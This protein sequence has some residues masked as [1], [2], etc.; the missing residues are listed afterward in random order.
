MSPI[1]SNNRS[2]E[3]VCL[4][5]TGLILVP[6]AAGWCLRQY[7][8]RKHTVVKE[9]QRSGKARPDDKR[10]KGTAV[11]CG[12]SI[13]GLWTAR[14]CADH[15][16][17]VLIIEPDGLG[18]PS[19]D[20]SDDDVQ[21]NKVLEPVRKRVLQYVSAHVFQSINLIALR[22]FFPRVEQEV[23][24]RGGLIL[25]FGGY[26]HTNY[27]IIHKIPRS[28]MSSLNIT[29]TTFITRH[30]YESILRQ[31]VLD[32]SPRIRCMTGSVSG[33]SS[34][35]SDP[36][37]ISG[38]TVRKARTDGSDDDSETQNIPAVFVA[39]CT[40]IAQ[41]G[42]KW[43]KRLHDI[44]G[45]EN[46]KGTLD[47]IRT[48][49]DIDSRFVTYRFFVPEDTWTV[50][51]SLIPMSLDKTGVLY[52]FIPQTGIDNRYFIINRLEG[53]RI[54]IA[55]GGWGN[56]QIP[57]NIKELEDYFRD[58]AR[59]ADLPAWIFPLA[60]ELVKIEKYTCKIAK[61]PRMSYIRYHDAPS[62]PRNFIAVGDAMMNT[63]PIFGQG[64]GK[65]LIG[66]IV[67]DSVLRATA[68]ESFESIDIGKK[69]FETHKEK[70]DEA[71]NGTKSIDYGFSTT[72]PASGETL[73][74]EAANAKLSDL[75]LQLCAEDAK[76]D[77]TLWYIRSFLAPTTDVLS[78]MILA[79]IFVVW[80]KRVL[81]I[82]KIANIA[83]A[84]RH[85]RSL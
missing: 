43:I 37:N 11:I 78:P 22:H 60:E 41:A 4:Y 51:D 85:S 19:A 13:S 84:A 56:P 68:T 15:F 40:G 27:G 75:V 65:A 67:L 39:D 28:L 20:E 58:F 7:L 80:L 44:S 79:K 59:K 26:V 23:V 83:N 9:L 52:A 2:F 49:Y 34:D 47:G 30:G 25:P 38:V 45:Q 76:V 63:N 31:F 48:S 8:L 69:Y 81:G 32:S 36:R 6:W 14:V 24:E 74:T 17:D 64:C 35:S 61:I 55:C 53:H 62:L 66:A 3:V 18:E 72:I 70:L 33:L 57:E 42:L 21:P 46:N 71:W 54:E 77:A 12:G 5:S 1:H 50:L 73:A 29:G 16:E 10:I 82:G